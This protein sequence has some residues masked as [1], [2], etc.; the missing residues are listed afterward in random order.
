MSKRLVRTVVIQPLALAIALLA[1]VSLGPERAAAQAAESIRGRVFNEREEK[2][3]R[4]LVGTNLDKVE[5]KIE[6]E[7]KGNKL[8]MLGS[9]LRREPSSG[10]IFIPEVFD[11]EYI[12]IPPEKK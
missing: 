8:Q 12:A 10:A 2:G 5:Y 4:L 6:Y 3:K 9:S 7:F 11:G 1:L